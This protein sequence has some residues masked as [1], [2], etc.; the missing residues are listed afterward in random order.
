MSF[1]VSRCA[2]GESPGVS[3]KGASR[4][5]PPPVLQ[6]GLRDCEASAALGRS[7]LVPPAR[8][9]FSPSDLRSRA[10]R[11]LRSLLR[12]LP[13]RILLPAGRQDPSRA[14]CSGTLNIVMAMAQG[15]PSKIRKP[16][17]A[18]PV[19]PSGDNGPRDDSPVLTGERQTGLGF[20][21]GAGMILTRPCLR[22]S[23]RLWPSGRDIPGCLFDR[24]EANP[25]QPRRTTSGARGAN[26]ALFG[27]GVET[28]G[29]AGP[30]KPP[31]SHR[32]GPV[33]RRECRSANIIYFLPDSC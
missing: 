18:I 31:A 32:W 24:A 14:R 27:P 22:A 17:V 30:I 2:S 12:G 8:C 3:L 6:G 33:P 11:A 4:K 20:V 26:P 16:A 28:P 25:L 23:R 21:N 1:G 29:A 10:T 15:L 19:R 9:G 13:Y 7:V 5:T